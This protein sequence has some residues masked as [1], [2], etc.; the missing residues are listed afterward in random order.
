MKLN[1]LYQQVEQKLPEHQVE[2]TVHRFLETLR[3]KA[4]NSHISVKHAPLFLNDQGPDMMLVTPKVRANKSNFWINKLIDQIPA[5]KKF[6]SRE[7]YIRAFT[8]LESVGS[9]PYV[10]I[11]L[12]G[13]RI[14]VCPSESF[15]RGFLD[16]QHTLDLKKVDNENLTYWITTL[17]SSVYKLLKDL[18]VS[19]EKITDDPLSYKEFIKQLEHVD[20]L[21]TPE[22]HRLLKRVKEADSPLDDDEETVLLDFLSRFMTSS[23]QYL[24]EKLD[25]D[26]NG[27]KVSPI[28]AFH[29][30]NG[31]LEVW[32]DSPVLLIKRKKYIE[33][34]DEKQIS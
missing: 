30:H 1:E 26:R 6:P 24:S 33:L 2:L 16:V 21:V 15:Y 27:F 14:G 22:R 7:T 31:N 12:D 20:R 29:K 3:E 9:D 13:T 18:N 17:K 4:K 11:P 10:M 25:P 5:W 28:E 19:T 34:H 8:S 32:V 23:H